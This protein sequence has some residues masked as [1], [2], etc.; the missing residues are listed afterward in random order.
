MKKFIY[1][2]RHD[3]CIR[4]SIHLPPLASDESSTSYLESELEI[5]LI[6]NMI[7]QD[8]VSQIRSLLPSVFEQRDKY[9][10]ANKLSLAQL[11]YLI[12]F[13][14]LESMRIHGGKF[15]RIFAYISNHS[16]LTSSFFP[17]LNY[18]C[19]QIFSLYTNL[20]LETNFGEGSLIEDDVDVSTF[21][22]QNMLIEEIIYL[23]VN[24]CH[25]EVSVRLASDRY[26]V[27]M[28]KKFPQLLW[29]SQSLTV[30]LNLLQVVTRSCNTNT[31]YVTFLSLPGTNFKLVLP[32]NLQ[33]RQEMLFNI[34]KLCVTWLKTSANKA[35]SQTN[36]LLHQYSL[37]FLNAQSQQN[38]Y[39]PTTLF[40]NTLNPQMMDRPVQS[41][42]DFEKE[43]KQ[44]VH[45][46]NQIDQSHLQVLS[47][48]H[49]MKICE[50]NRLFVGSNEVHPGKINFRFSTISFKQLFIPKK[51]FLFQLRWHH[52]VSFYFLFLSKELT[53]LPLL[54]I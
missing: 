26:I 45:S 8:H 23:L 31:N 50:A 49:N 24:F 22:K 53:H 34:T 16:L 19:D 1:F 17:L 9:S 38:Q 13:Y 43:S 4:I 46:K 40:N 20:M 15:S 18:L 37:S 3:A 10:Q 25:K 6:I 54:R 36:A 33:N 21:Y 5:S 11:V 14:K 7:H 52:L 27:D 48:E 39:I 28:V 35:H 41:L 47:Q 32:D 44:I 30:L 42:I 2:D 12:S 29:S 51:V